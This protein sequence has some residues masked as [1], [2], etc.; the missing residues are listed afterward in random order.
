MATRNTEKIYDEQIM[1]LVEAII[2]ICRKHEI[3]MV[4]DF[5]L[6]NEDE[7][8]LSCTSAYRGHNGKLPERQAIAIAALL[9]DRELTIN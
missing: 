6:V 7:K 9:S 3:C 8:D 5:S 2:D 1:P 4:V